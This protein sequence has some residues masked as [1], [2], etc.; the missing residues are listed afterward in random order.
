M[1]T[2]RKA[3]VYRSQ[4]N[5]LF[6]QGRWFVVNRDLLYVMDLEYAALVSLLCNIGQMR[7]DE[8]DPEWFR[9]SE[10]KVQYQLKISRSKQTRMV[11][12][13]ADRGFLSVKYDGMPR[14]RRLRV[15]F[16][17]LDNAVRVAMAE[18]Q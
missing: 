2:N 14:R 17:V 1:R 7:H 16:G 10:K 5:R 4:L 6:D 3:T 8:Q 13:L 11:K 15:N 12:S 18:E 9:C